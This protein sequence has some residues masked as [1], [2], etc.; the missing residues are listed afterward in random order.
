MLSNGETQK[1]VTTEV[2]VLWQHCK[3]VILNL[4]WK[5]L[6]LF[7]WHLILNIL[8]CLVLITIL[9]LNTS[10]Y[11]NTL[12]KYPRIFIFSIKFLFHWFKKKNKTVAYFKFALMVIYFINLTEDTFFCTSLQFIVF[13]NK[14][15][16]QTCFQI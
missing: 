12:F 4:F 5:I 15:V 11:P 9:N 2:S 10:I 13:N 14:T 7:Y 3:Y 16:K 6:S 8:M 1:S